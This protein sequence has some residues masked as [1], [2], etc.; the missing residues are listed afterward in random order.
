MKT[1]WSNGVFEEKCY[2][3]TAFEWVKCTC[4]KLN[5]VSTNSKRKLMR[6]R[7]KTNIIPWTVTSWLSKLVVTLL[8][9]RYGWYCVLQEKLSHSR[10][11]NFDVK[12]NFLLTKS[13][14]KELNF[15]L[16]WWRSS[17]RPSQGF[18]PYRRPPPKVLSMR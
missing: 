11:F 14:R 9:L 13:I 15:Y 17:V 3:I 10:H 5:S 2:I 7:K 12:Q 18:E 8:C 1:S 6:R 16:T 4:Q